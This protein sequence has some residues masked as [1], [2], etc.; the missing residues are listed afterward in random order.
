M[1]APARAPDWRDALG[2]AVRNVH[3]QVTPE[4]VLDV[5]KV[6][7]Q[8]AERLLNHAQRATA[9]SQFV[10]LCGGD[11]VSQQASL[12]FN[13][14]IALLVEQCREYGNQLKFAGESLNAVAENYGYSEQQIESSFRSA[15]PENIS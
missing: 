11:P 5:R 2:A 10:G 15:G 12:A 13:Q 8:E 9:Q 1:T 14:R 7:L 6:L 4:N 3:L